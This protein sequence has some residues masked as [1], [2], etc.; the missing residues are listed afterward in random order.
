MYTWRASCEMF[1]LPAAAARTPTCGTLRSGDH[2]RVTRHTW[3]SPDMPVS[4]S[5][6][7]A[8]A[9]AMAGSTQVS[10]TDLRLPMAANMLRSLI[11][12]ASEVTAGSSRPSRQGLPHLWRLLLRRQQA[13]HRVAPLLLLQ[14]CEDAAVAGVHDKEH[15]APREGQQV[16][17][18]QPALVCARGGGGADADSR[19]VWPA[20]TNWAIQGWSL[21]AM[22]LPYLW[23]H[24]H[25]VRTLQP[26]RG[27]PA[28]CETAARLL[29]TP[30]DVGVANADVWAAQP[31]GN[32]PCALG[33]C[34]W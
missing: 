24:R 10:P 17:R 18:V 5:P 21:Q 31:A 33:A 32:I 6:M 19:A 30:E 3:T 27:S 12:E 22:A 7:E 26:A 28:R 34:G 29:C 14:H 16:F 25:D 23:P 4:C 15:G 20:G 2:C 9:A 8:A 13:A 1:P 11:Q